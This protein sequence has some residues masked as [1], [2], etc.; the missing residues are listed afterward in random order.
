MIRFTKSGENESENEMVALAK[1]R[2][3]L[4]EVSIFTYTISKGGQ[5][6]HP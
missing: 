4:E 6:I 3:V 5:T 2:A 1:C